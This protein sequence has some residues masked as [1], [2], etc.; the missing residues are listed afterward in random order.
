MLLVLY[1][2]MS[3][4]KSNTYIV[5]KDNQVDLTVLQILQ[6]DVIYECIS[7]NFSSSFFE[8]KFSTFMLLT[9]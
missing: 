3:C 9:G 6:K 5:P 7:P 8:S 2:A 1:A 4:Q